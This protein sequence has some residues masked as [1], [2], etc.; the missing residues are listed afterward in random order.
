MDMEPEKARITL[1]V[2]P[3]VPLVTVSSQPT[4]C[5]SC[6]ASAAFS[7]RSLGIG[8]SGKVRHHEHE[9]VSPHGINAQHDAADV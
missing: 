8:N 7:Q 5:K 4:S 3:N 6:H 9:M 2:Q 1:M